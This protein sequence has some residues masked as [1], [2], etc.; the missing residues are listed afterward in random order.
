MVLVSKTMILTLIHLDTMEYFSSIIA[1][2]DKS[3]KFFGLSPKP[4]TAPD[5]NSKPLQDSPRLPPIEQ[6]SFINKKTDSSA[7]F[8]SPSSSSYNSYLTQ[9]YP[10]DGSDSGHRSHRHSNHHHHHHHHRHHRHHHYPLQELGTHDPRWWYLPSGSVHAPRPS[11]SPI[12]HYM[13]PK[14]YEAS[15]MRGRFVVDSRSLALPTRRY[16]DCR[17]EVCNPSRKTP[18]GFKWVAYQ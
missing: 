15:T 2:M 4:T 13:P 10:I 7:P 16:D 6:N 11:Q 5:G 17:C 3:V 18:R 1:G 8:H 9:V 12:V 14:W